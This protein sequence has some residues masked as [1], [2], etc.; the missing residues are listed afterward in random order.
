MNSCYRY[1]WLLRLLVQC[2]L[3]VV[4]VEDQLAV[5]Q[6]CRDGLERMTSNAFY[7]VGGECE[8]CMTQLDLTKLLVLVGWM[9]GSN[10]SNF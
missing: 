10:R 2:Y 7:R 1:E 4:G 3:T 5:E 6:A 9:Q 8:E